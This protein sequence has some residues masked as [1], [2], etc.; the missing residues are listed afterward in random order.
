MLN[1]ILKAPVFVSVLI[2]VLGVGIWIGASTVGERGTES[3][4]NIPQAALFL[5]EREGVI[6][7]NV[8]GDNLGS[9]QFTEAPLG[10]SIRSTRVTRVLDG[11]TIEIESGERVKYLG[12][13]APESGRPFST[14]ATRE[15]ERLV[16]GRMVNLEFDVKRKDRF[17]R[18]LAYVWVGDNLINREIV[19]NG[20]AL[21]KV[22]Q[23]NVKHKAL[24]LGAE[25]EARI[26]CR[27]LWANDCVR[28]QKQK[29]KKTLCVT[30]VNINANAPGNDNK[31]KNGEWIELKNTCPQAVSMNNW[32]LKD[33]SLRNEYKFDD[34][35]LDGA[36]SVILYSGCGLN[37]QEK[38][39]WQCPERRFAVW[40]NDGDHA[41][42][43]DAV[44]N[45]IAE[46]QY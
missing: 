22:V 42:L 32:L 24:I 11:D 27:G 12:I 16:A 35:T 20:Y 46:Y 28:N 5:A 10:D 18:I 23:P 44:G 8:A 39:Y 17:G 31:N 40:S 6:N 13:D 29:V 3:Q 19:K 43:Y 14:K 37:T 2:A 1:R 38:L 45:L 21:S 36:R 26:G 41:F 7:G 34:F 4:D 9:G 33:S 30:I 15:N 25:N